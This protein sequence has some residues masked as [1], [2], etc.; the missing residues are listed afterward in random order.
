[1]YEPVNI[2]IEIMQTQCYAQSTNDGEIIVEVG[3]GD[4]FA[5]KNKYS[6]I[7]F[8]SSRIMQTT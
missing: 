5:W 8:S 7:V 3:A 1:M 2:T 4:F 6:M